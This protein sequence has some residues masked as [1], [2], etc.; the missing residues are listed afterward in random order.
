MKRPALII[1]LLFSFASAA[2]G[3]L[4]EF[5]RVDFGPLHWLSKGDIILG[6]GITRRENRI[7]VDRA[8][9]EGYLSKES[10]VKS[11]KLIDKNNVLTILVSE[12][13]PLCAV[14]LKAKNR[15]VLCEADQGGRIVSAGRVHRKDAPLIVV[16]AG[17]QGSALPAKVQ[18]LI[19]VFG[20]LKKRSIWRELGQITVRQDGMCDVLLKSRPTV[21][22][23]SGDYGSFVRLEAVAGQIDRAGR[24]PK[25]V[26]VRD[27][28]AVAGA[29]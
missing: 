6:A 8:K 16:Q 27:A 26:V 21:F 14:A 2:S 13:E 24:Y 1:G 22:A 11:Y 15:T 18:S 12:Y 9:L 20:E 5:D 19:A 4:R 23:L 10:M 17:E 3:A 28:F 25:S 29:D 7:L